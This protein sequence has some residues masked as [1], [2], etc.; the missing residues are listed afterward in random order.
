M[1]RAFAFPILVSLT[2]LLIRLLVSGP[3]K[4]ASQEHP[5]FRFSKGLATFLLVGLLA[6]ASA[7][8]ALMWPHVHMELEDWIFTTGMG[9]CGVGTYIYMD[10]YVLKFWDDH[11]TYGMRN[12]AIL[13]YRDIISAGMSDGGRTLDIKTST[14]KVRIS[15][16]LSSIEDAAK[17]LRS[18]LN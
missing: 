14:G 9:I 15:G 12:P 8:I 5:E 10:K 2:S 13:Y 7:R 17:L 16:Y 4:S 6:L 11:L 18:K 3:R 1:L